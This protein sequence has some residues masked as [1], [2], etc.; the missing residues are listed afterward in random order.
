M[1]GYCA[2]VPLPRVF[3]SR[4][5]LRW[6]RTGQRHTRPHA[7]SYRAQPFHLNLEWANHLL[8]WILCRAEV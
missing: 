1:K 8:Q 6:L 2:T 4:E 7:I 5:Y 3:G